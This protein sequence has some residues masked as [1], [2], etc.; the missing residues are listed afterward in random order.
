MKQGVVAPMG[1][2]ECHHI[3]GCTTWN[4]P[5]NIVL[6]PCIFHDVITKLQKGVH[7]YM[8]LFRKSLME[9]LNGLIF[10]DWRGRLVKDNEA[11]CTKLIMI[12][13][14]G[15]YHHCLRQHICDKNVRLAPVK[16]I[17]EWIKKVVKKLKL[18]IDP[19]YVQN[20]WLVYPN[21][22]YDNAGKLIS[23]PATM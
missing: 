4:D 18:G 12:S 3:N 2:W 6:L 15:T 13:C 22:F 14:I 19:T 10:Y 21:Y 9:E 8:K 23:A 11:W 17:Q 1:L 5:K 20:T 16:Q 7:R